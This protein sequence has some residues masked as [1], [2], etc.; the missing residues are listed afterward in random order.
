MPSNPQPQAQMQSNY[1]A[2]K[3]QNPQT[4]HWLHQS[5]IPNALPAYNILKRN[6]TSSLDLALDSQLF[7]NG[8]KS[9]NTPGYG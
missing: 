1:K 4:L 3:L 6:C 9:S 7:Q 8:S 2:L 5:E